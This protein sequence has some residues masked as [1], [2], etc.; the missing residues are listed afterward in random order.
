MMSTST[1]N[2]YAMIREILDRLG[3]SEWTI[4]KPSPTVPDDGEYLCILNKLTPPYK[5]AEFE[6]HTDLFQFGIQC[7]KLVLA[8][9]KGVS[10]A[11]RI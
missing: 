11:K 10:E 6:L 1:P 3:F 8:I 5:Q 7:Q 9:K 2:R 4:L